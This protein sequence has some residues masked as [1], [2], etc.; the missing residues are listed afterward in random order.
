[1]SRNTLLFPIRRVAIVDGLSGPEGAGAGELFIAGRGGEDAG[2]GEMRE[3][4]G[5][6]RDAAGAQHEHILPRL[7]R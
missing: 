2:A 7:E 3:L 4:Q 6:D 5:E 1:V